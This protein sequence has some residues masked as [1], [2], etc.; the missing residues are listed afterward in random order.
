[1]ADSVDLLPE[2]GLQTSDLQP[3]HGAFLFV[4][5]PFNRRLVLTVLLG[6]PAIGIV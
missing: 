5:K 1:M 2:R 6:Y 3:S 4:V